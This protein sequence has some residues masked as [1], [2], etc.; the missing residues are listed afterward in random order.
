VVIVFT[1]RD[2]IFE[3]NKKKIVK[4]LPGSG[5]RGSRARGEAE[6][7]GEASV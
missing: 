3:S 1:V 5:G 4:S 7:L 2:G 6:E